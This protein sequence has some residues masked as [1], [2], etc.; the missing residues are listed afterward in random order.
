MTVDDLNYGYDRSF[1]TEPMENIVLCRVPFGWHRPKVS[2]GASRQ[3]R[4]GTVTAVGARDGIPFS[5]RV[6]HAHYDALRIERG[7]LSTAASA[8]R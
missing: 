4:S 2:G 3:M 8:T 6:F 7:L 1:E 5:G